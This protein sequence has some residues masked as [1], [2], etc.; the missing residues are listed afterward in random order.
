MECSLEGLHVL[1]NERAFL[2]EEGTRDVVTRQ[3]KIWLTSCGSSRKLLASLD[4]GH[5]HELD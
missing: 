1:L 2:N 3:P 4:M 5:G